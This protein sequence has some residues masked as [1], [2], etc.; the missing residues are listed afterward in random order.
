V[1]IMGTNEFMNLRSP[2][3]FMNHFFVLDFIFFEFGE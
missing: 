3:E 2:E 1:P